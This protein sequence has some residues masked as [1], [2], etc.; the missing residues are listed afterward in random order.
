MSV[1]DDEIA[2]EL[3][4]TILKYNVSCKEMMTDF[5]R[6]L[7]VVS[8]TS[9]ITEDSLADLV[10]VVPF[11]GEVNDALQKIGINPDFN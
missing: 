2:E 6:K 8:L 9:E 5:G 1:V 7:T 3:K 4:E 11:V 10:A